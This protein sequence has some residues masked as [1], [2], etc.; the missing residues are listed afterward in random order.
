MKMQEHKL[1]WKYFWQLVDLISKS[2]SKSKC[3]WIFG[4]FLSAVHTVFPFLSLCV[5]RSKRTARDRQKTWSPDYLA[6]PAFMQDAPPVGGFATSWLHFLALCQKTESSSVKEK[7]E[8]EEKDT[9]V[10]G[11]ETDE[12]GFCC[13]CCESEWFITRRK[14]CAEIDIFL[15]LKYAQMHTFYLLM[16]QKT[17]M[18]NVLSWTQISGPL[19]L[20]TKTHKHCTL[21][22]CLRHH[23]LFPP[24]LSPFPSITPSLAFNS[25][26]IHSPFISFVSLLLSVPP[27]ISRYSVNVLTRA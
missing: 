16:C 27:S 20:H 26:S 18:S 2:A 9:E 17:Q 24:D 23:L 15:T 1:T 6:S 14:T 8:Q 19:L 5:C 22:L 13:S 7:G 12:R 21:A 10:E 11:R 4:L 25:A 3:K